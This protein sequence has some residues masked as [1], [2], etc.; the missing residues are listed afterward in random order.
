MQVMN[1]IVNGVGSLEFDDASSTSEDTNNMMFD[2]L[3]DQ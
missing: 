1:D 3:H 2:P